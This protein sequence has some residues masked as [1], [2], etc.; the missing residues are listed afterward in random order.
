MSGSENWS[1]NLSDKQ[2]IQAA[3]MRFLKAVTEYS[4]SLEEFEN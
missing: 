3:E 4:T 2:K 1:L